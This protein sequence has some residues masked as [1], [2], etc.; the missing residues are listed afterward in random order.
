MD[1]AAKTNLRTWGVTGAISLAVV[2]RLHDP[3]TRR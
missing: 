1:D 3:R 2:G